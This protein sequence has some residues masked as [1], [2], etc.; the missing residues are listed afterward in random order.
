MRCFVAVD[1]EEPSLLDKL[2]EVQRTLAGTGSRL[3]LVDRLLMHFTLRFI[4]EINELRKR[5]IIEALSDVSFPKF[6]V[7]VRGL[8]AFPSLS[9]P[10]VVWAG[11]GKGS[12]MLIS[13]A[14]EVNERLDRLGFIRKEKR[15]FSP[16]LTIA[17]VKMFTP[18]LVKVIKQ[19]SDTIFGEFVAEELRLKRS[20]LTPKG[21][22]Y[23]T[24]WALPLK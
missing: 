22:I 6:E 16:H 17:R 23:S 18:Q 20:I 24:L 14:K 21:P 7:E 4:G 15:P 3:K 2:E 8:G 10:R 13:L 9:R 12:D 19:H 5:Q 1:V 11:A